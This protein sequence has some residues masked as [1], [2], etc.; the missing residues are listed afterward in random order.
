MAN[1]PGMGF[2]IGNKL[3]PKN[4]V[5]RAFRQNGVPM[6]DVT[7]YG[8]WPQVPAGGN[9]CV[10]NGSDPALTNNSGGQLVIRTLGVYYESIATGNVFVNIV[11]ADTTLN[12]GDTIVYSDI[13]V[14]LTTDDLPV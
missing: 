13:Q 11:H 10:F 14:T 5:F 4:F 7:E 1:S 12:N 6:N 2:I 8:A 9:V 3:G